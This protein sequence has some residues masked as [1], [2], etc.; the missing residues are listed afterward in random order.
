MSHLDHL[1]TT[2]SLSDVAELLGFKPKALSY[3]LYIKSNSTKY[4]EFEIPKRS[5]GVRKIC[6]PTKELKSVQKRLS[7]LLQ[8]CIDEINSRKGVK[9]VLSHGFRRK[10]SI[11]SN[12]EYHRNRRYIF[13][14]DIDDYFG[15][16]NFGRV[17]GF[18][19]KNKN[20][21]LH[22]SVATVLAQIACHENELP[23]GSPCSP[24]IT[25]LITHAL[26]I[27]LADL[28]FKSNCYYSRYADDLTF[29]TNCKSIPR[30]IAAKDAHSGKWM[31]GKSLTKLIIKAGFSI[32]QSKTRL[33]YKH[34]RQDVTGLLV[35]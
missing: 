24:V 3:I 6:A 2:S 18:F 27:R 30:T 1:K 16:I 34:S 17:R 8:D 23:Q 5:G 15:T 9:S 29:S 21:E 10:Y 26:D 25:N 4:T 35:N 12:A 7:I 20:F 19:I 11:I 22:P 33:Q 28:A 31:P 32:N 14:I 13:N